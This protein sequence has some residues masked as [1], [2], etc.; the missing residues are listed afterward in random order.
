MRFLMQTDGR[1]AKFIVVAKRL[2]AF[3]LAPLNVK[4]AEGNIDVLHTICL[5][6]KFYLR[7]AIKAILLTFSHQSLTD[8]T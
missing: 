4:C 8:G 7:S 2:C 3:R 1:I 6:K 5:Y